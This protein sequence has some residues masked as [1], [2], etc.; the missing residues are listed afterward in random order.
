MHHLVISPISEMKKPETPRKNSNWRTKVIMPKP[1]DL[2]LVFLFRLSNQRDTRHIQSQTNRI[3]QITIYKGSSLCDLTG[4]FFLNLLSVYIWHVYVEHAFIQRYTYAMTC[5]EVRGQLSGVSSHP[6]PRV[7]ESNSG[8]P[9]F[10]L[11][12]HLTA[13][14]VELSQ[15]PY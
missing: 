9:A 1:S 13:P 2:W 11:L 5:V 15:C 4:L 14:A 10:N 3:L 6:L 8:S 7:L 12:N